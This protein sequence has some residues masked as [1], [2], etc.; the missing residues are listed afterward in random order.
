MYTDSF[1]ESNET[2]ILK[3][4]RFQNTPDFWNSKNKGKFWTKVKLFQFKIPAI[5]K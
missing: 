2:P 3:L 5:L 1:S 4:P